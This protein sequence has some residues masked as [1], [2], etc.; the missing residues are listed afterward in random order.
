MKISIDTINLILWTNDTSKFD[1]KQLNDNKL[2]YINYI[3]LSSDANTANTKMLI[4]VSK[5]YKLSEIKKWLKGA[6]SL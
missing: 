5:E 4:N 2:S 6:Y 3:G 1:L